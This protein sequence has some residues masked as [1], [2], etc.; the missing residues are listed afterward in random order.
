MAMALSP[1]TP[2]PLLHSH[3][4]ATFSI[5]IRGF[6]YCGSYCTV[7]AKAPIT[8]TFAGGTEPKASLQ[9]SSQQ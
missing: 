5:L 1:A 8:K 4:E 7:E 3:T 6:P 2:A 9:L